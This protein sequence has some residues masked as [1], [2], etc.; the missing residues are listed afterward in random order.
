MEGLASEARIQIITPK[1]AG[2]DPRHESR[3]CYRITREIA[4][5]AGN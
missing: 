2:D 1:D 3:V 4:A 5:Q